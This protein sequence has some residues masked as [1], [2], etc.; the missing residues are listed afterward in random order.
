V[1]P[2]SALMD[3]PP[4]VTVKSIL[5]NKGYPMKLVNKKI[6]YRFNYLIKNKFNKNKDD[7]IVEKIDNKMVSM[8]IPYFGN[9]DIKIIVQNFVEVRYTIPKKL[10]TLIKSGKDKLD[11]QRV[12]EIIYKIL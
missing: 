2:K 8:N 9:K 10:D 7:N 12:T 5:R 11:L 4:L 3:P 6:N 1:M